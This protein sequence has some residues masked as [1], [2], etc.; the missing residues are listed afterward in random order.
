LEIKD[1]GLQ[2]D[3][4]KIDSLKADAASEAAKLKAEGR[5]DVLKAE[6]WYSKHR[7]LAY[8]VGAIV[9]VALIIW[10]VHHYYGS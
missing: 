9:L 3:Q 4:S 6:S 10:T 8:S 2:S 7:E 1:M 5:G